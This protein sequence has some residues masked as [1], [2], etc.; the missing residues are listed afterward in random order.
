MPL[1]DLDNKYKD[2]AEKLIRDAKKK[3]NSNKTS[4][5][6]NQWEAEGGLERMAAVAGASAV[7]SAAATAA[8]FAAI[9][10]GI[11][12]GAATFG[13]GPAVGVAL[14]YGLAKSLQEYRYQSNSSQLKKGLVREEHDDDEEGEPGGSYAINDLELLIPA[15]QKVLKKFTRVKRRVDQT[16]GG[17]TEVAST[18][19]HA[20]TALKSFA[21]NQGWTKTS[22]T[23]F[24]SSG[25][26][27]KDHELSDRLFELRFYGQMLFNY[28][29]KLLDT[30]V[31]P[32]RDKIADASQVIFAHVIRQV[33]FTGNHAHCD[34]CYGMSKKEFSAR[35]AQ[36]E[37]EAKQRKGNQV[38]P[39][40]N[41]EADT[42][43]N[44]AVRALGSG[45]NLREGLAS[46]QGQA[47]NG[48]QGTMANDRIATY[49]FRGGVASPAVMGAA[50]YGADLLHLMA[51]EGPTVASGAV[52]AGMG[53]GSGVAMAELVRTITNRLTR[54]SVLKA[55]RLQGAFQ[56]LSE[57]GDSQSEALA[58]FKKLLE[59]DNVVNRA[60]R[61]AEK[62][63]NYIKKLDKIQAKFEPEYRRV[64]AARS[65]ERSALGSCD[66]AYALAYG[67]NYFFR[68]CSKL[69]AFVV[70]LE[71]I[72]L[73]IDL[74]CSRLI[75]GVKK[76]D[77]I[78]PDAPTPP[79]PVTVK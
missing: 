76:G 36:I 60:P 41:S 35:L 79:K 62:I 22:K 28:V 39:S 78:K 7:T 37:R 50:R 46:L 47:Q 15:V 67:V 27:S 42:T 54:R 23:M 53:A 9:T 73:Q 31:L 4:V 12:L 29:Q 71:V 11:A 10:G 34:K 66:H 49:A 32:K 72:L 57:Q 1:V 65:L 48:A 21:K 52:G 55:N 33:H 64:S 51:T 58:E 8:A 61:V 20:K 3:A 2:R 70:Y 16:G 14:T 45:G 63:V 43:H 30:I 25:K 40:Y 74:E 59:G 6:L 77:V 44:H 38:G 75:P 19:R 24:A 26:A 18:L 17:L 13:V 69:L 5:A 68:N 56:L